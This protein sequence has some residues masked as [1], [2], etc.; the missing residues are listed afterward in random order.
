[1]AGSTAHVEVIQ[2]AQPTSEILD[3]PLQAA[4]GLFDAVFVTGG[5]DMVVEV[6]RALRDTGHHVGSQCAFVCCYNDPAR[7]AT[8]DPSL[9]NIDIQPEA[10]GRA[11]AEMLLWRLANPN[12][13][14]RRLSVGP[15]LVE[16]EA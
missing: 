11:A 3:G 4:G 13:E 15:R 14:Q 1:M 16:V 10:I 2:S 6:Y 8:L 9:P 5:D 12:A 7:L